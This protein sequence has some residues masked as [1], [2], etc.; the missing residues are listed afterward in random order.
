LDSFLNSH[1]QTNCQNVSTRNLYLLP[2]AVCAIEEFD[3]TTIIILFSRLSRYCE[4][5]LLLLL[6]TENLLHVEVYA[7]RPTIELP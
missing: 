6:R 4:N 7:E 3:I 5:L 2:L 1:L